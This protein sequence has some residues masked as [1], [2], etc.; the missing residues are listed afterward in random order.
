M[1][2]SLRELNKKQILIDAGDEK[3]ITFRRLKK[4]KFLK[5]AKE[6]PESEFH[7]GAAIV[8]EATRELDGEFDALQVFL[9]EPPASAH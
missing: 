4:T 9:G 5:G 3:I 8:V 1:R 6:V 7:A 2:G